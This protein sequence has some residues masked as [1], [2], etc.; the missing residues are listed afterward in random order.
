MYQQHNGDK[1]QCHNNILKHFFTSV[2]KFGAG[3]LKLISEVN[4]T[5]NQ[6]YMQTMM[7]FILI[8]FTN[9]SDDHMLNVK[10]S[11]C[12]PPHLCCT[13]YVEMI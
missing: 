3:T 5:I 1:D 9:Y 7:K 2:I 4:Y 13:H 6:T 12:L 11:N 8:I 10:A